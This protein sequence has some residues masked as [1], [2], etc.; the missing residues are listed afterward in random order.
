MGVDLGAEAADGWEGRAGEPALVVERGGEEI[1]EVVINV[2]GGS[3]LGQLR[4][5]FLL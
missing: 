1:A 5:S 4:K 3:E 2:E